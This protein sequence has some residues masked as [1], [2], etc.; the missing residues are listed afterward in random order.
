MNFSFVFLF[1]IIAYHFLFFFICIAH[2][3]NPCTRTKY[4][5]RFNRLLIFKYMFVVETILTYKFSFMNMNIFICVDLRRITIAA[6]C[7]ETDFCGHSNSFDWS[8]NKRHFCC[9]VQFFSRQKDR[10]LESIFVQFFFIVVGERSNTVD[11]VVDLPKLCVSYIFVCYEDTIGSFMMCAYG[12][13]MFHM[14]TL[15]KWAFEIDW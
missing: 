10:V 14:F 15:S 6:K 9:L 1:I 8:S 12:L 7:T 13:P 3:I 5:I 2:N 4:I 11:V